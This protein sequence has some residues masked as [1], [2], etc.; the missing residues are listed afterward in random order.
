MPAKNGSGKLKVTRT[1]DTEILLTR[2][3]DAPRRLVFEAMSKPEYVRRWWCCIDGYTMPVCDIDFRVGG[4]WRYVMVSPEGHEV[5]FNGVYREIAAPERIVNT[6]VF[7]PYPD[8]PAVCTMTLEER[9]G[10][11]FYKNVVVHDTKEACDGHLNSG[12]ES[13]ANIAMDR[14]E[15]IAQSLAANRDG[16]IAS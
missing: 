8:H 13:G 7:E 16:L 4:K 3:F 1:S 15:E 10:K 14:I 6:E 9:D 11:T 5:A 2:V 12:M